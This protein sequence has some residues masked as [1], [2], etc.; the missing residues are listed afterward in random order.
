[1]RVVDEETLHAAD[2]ETEAPK[3][4]E[5]KH[6]EDAEEVKISPPPAPLPEPE[7]LP[8]E[9]F[10]P[11][12]PKRKPRKPKESKGEILVPALEK[13]K[14]AFVEPSKLRK[15]RL[16]EKIEC[17]NGCGKQITR[18]A[19]SYTHNKTCQALKEKESGH[20]H[21]V[22]YVEPD[23]ERKEAEK[24]RRRQEA[25]EIHPNVEFMERLKKAAIAYRQL[26]DQK[27]GLLIRHYFQ[28]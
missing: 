26:E 15:E 14:N 24:A 22:T 13:A 6:A 9:K 1:M 25:P 17:P 11:V 4:E 19:A 2:L 20:V 27:H 3:D 10:V 12:K 23:F 7:V 18:H 16:K 28:H 21:E 5:T 8:E